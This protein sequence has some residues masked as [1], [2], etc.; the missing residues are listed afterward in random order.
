MSHS[1]RSQDTRTALFNPFLN[2]I[3]WN[4][5]AG[6]PRLRQKAVNNPVPQMFHTGATLRFASQISTWA[7]HVRRKL[8]KRALAWQCF[9]ESGT[10]LVQDALYI[11]QQGREFIWEARQMAVAKRGAN[12][13]E[14]LCP[15]RDSKPWASLKLAMTATWLTVL[16]I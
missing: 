9:S 7:S 13:S 3:V 10:G 8:T 6:E 11:S 15:G 2:R 4:R 14:L 16:G 5:G 12:N 1:W